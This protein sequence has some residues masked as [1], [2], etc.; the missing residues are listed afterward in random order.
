M[1]SSCLFLKKKQILKKKD[2]CEVWRKRANELKLTLN[3]A[4]VLSEAEDAYLIAQFV[5]AIRYL[6]HTSAYVSTRQHTS[7]YASIRTRISLLSS[8]VRYATYTIRQHTSAHVSIRQH[9]Y[10][11]LVA[12]FV[13]AIR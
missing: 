4:G 6:Q 7:A 5:H 9:T 13:H 2:T 11:Y 12:W 3:A 1:S 8:C 10:A